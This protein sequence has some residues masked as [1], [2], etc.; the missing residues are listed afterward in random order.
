M[1]FTSAAVR[2][3][4]LCEAWST[5]LDRRLAFKIAGYRS[6]T[7]GVEKFDTSLLPNSIRVGAQAFGLGY[8]L[9]ARMTAR[10]MAR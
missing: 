5:A 8:A 10:L 1:R 7:M 4:T 6:Y 3:T 2:A 9:F